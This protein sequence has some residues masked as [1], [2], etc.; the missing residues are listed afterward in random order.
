[1]HFRRDPYDSVAAGILG[2]CGTDNQ[3][4]TGIESKWD[5]VLTGTPGKLIS[6]K[7]SNLQEIPDSQ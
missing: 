6:S 5:D 4:I 7:G 1:M 3:G 2:F